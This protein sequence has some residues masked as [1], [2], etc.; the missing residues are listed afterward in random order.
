MKKAR[1]VNQF[2][3]DLTGIGVAEEAVRLHWGYLEPFGRALIIPSSV[4]N[5]LQV[6][7]EE[8]DRF[9][10]M[11]DV[12]ASQKNAILERVE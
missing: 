7:C 8:L 11:L 6:R 2:V 12:I 9:A 4:S 1:E 3:E 5:R 10:S